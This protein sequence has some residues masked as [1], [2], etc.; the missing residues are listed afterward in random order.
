MAAIIATAQNYWI[1]TSALT[2]TLNALGEANRVQ[3]SVASG[4]QIMCYIR[5][6][7]GL[8]FDEGHN[9]RRWP[10]TVSPTFFNTNTHKYLY[11][12]IPRTTAIGTQAMVWFPSQLLDINGCAIDE[13]GEPA[14]QVG[15]P[16]YYYIWLQGII[17]SSGDY[18]TTNRTWTAEM[19]FGKKG[20]KCC[21]TQ[22][23]PTPGPPPP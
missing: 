20:T 9:Y 3:A 14:E 21:F 13:E 7:D 23:G 8:D 12:V 10:L 19:D 2:I 22:T 18:G 11:V 4:A 15:N 1:S 5:G 16:D 17:S 6:V